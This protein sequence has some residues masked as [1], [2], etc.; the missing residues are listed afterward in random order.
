M[1]KSGHRLESAGSA[2]YLPNFLRAPESSIKP[3][4]SLHRPLPLRVRGTGRAIGNFG[5]VA[6]AMMLRGGK[7]FRVH[8]C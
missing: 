4:S 8:Q 7:V 1:R 6:N 2:V 3:P 5:K